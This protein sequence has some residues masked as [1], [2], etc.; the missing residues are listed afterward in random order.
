MSTRGVSSKRDVPARQPLD[1]VGVLSKSTIVLYKFRSVRSLEGAFR[2]NQVVA[3]TKTEYAE[4]LNGGDLGGE[5]LQQL[6]GFAQVEPILCIYDAHP[7][8]I[9]AALETRV[10]EDLTTLPEESG[11]WER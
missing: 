1:F 3:T 10:R 11:S 9:T 8:L 6:G 4:V 7:G 2:V 5:G